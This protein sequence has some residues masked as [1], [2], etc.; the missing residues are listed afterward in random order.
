MTY[1]ISRIYNFYKREKENNLFL[2]N[3]RRK[4]KKRKKF[5]RFL[6]FPFYFMWKVIKYNNRKKEKK[7]H[8]YIKMFWILRRTEA[9]L[10]SFNNNTSKN[11]SR[12]YER[13]DTGE[14]ILIFILNKIFIF[15]HRFH[16]LPSNE[17]M[18]EVGKGKNKSRINIFRGRKR[19]R[20]EK[21]VEEK[22]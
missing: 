11:I 22:K 4:P 21:K 16:P 1:Q 2:I 7:I 17:W 10:N 15:T 3:L 12:N 19:T 13:K 9:F 8:T 18:E 14:F 20:R 6:F 5:V